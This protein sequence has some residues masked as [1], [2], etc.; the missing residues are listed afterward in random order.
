[1]AG[2]P[3]PA[4]VYDRAVEEG[5]RRLG[6][7]TVELIATGFIAGFTVTFGIAALGITE[8]SIEPQWGH[9]AH[10]AG[11]LALGTSIVFLVVGRA[12]LFNENFFDPVAKAVDSDS[13]MLRPLLRL[14]TYTFVFNL[15]GGGFMA[16]VLSVDGA[17]P[18]GS[19]EILRRLAEEVVA[20]NA[21]AEFSD[22]ISGGVLV[23]LLS[24]L[25]GTTDSIGSRMA[26]AYVVG[27]LLALGPF[28]H[29]VV[30]ALHVLF[31]MLFGAPIGPLEAVET[32]AIVTAGNLVG[33]I[34]IG[35]STHIVQARGARESGG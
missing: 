31:G 29:V 15:L 19:G 35:T 2:A 34:G 13:W 3:T 14:W 16:V 20:R 21:L 6:Q 25:L 1:M 5:E 17:L 7:S 23:T 12:E 33:G 4:E 32:T 9:V 22:A 8:A 26:L 10:V 27:F 28:D 18:P 24:F 30:T 11:A